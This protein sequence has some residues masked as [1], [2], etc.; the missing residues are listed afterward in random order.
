M[1]GDIDIDMADRMALLSKIKNTNATMIKDGRTVKHPTGIYVT[2]I[3]FNP[4]VNGSAIE[5]KE[6]EKMGY[7]KLDILN[8]NLY[9]RVKD[10]VHMQSLMKDPDWSRLNDRSF[11]EKITHIG[12]HYD[13]MK[14]MPE[15]IDSI[16]RMAMFLSV[17]RPAKR[18]L[19]GLPWKDV[20]KSVW[21]E[22]KDGGYWYKKS[23]SISYATMVVVNMNLEIEEE[24]KLSNESN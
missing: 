1:I 3:P 21:L 18:Y 11:V 20:A 16:P 2:D 14:L 4:L 6:A 5:Y 23:H 9:S 13:T 8:V 17:I 24:S 19:I 12:N 7:Y 15:P 10:E 22:P